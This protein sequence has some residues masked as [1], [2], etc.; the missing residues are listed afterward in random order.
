MSLRNSYWA[1]VRL[2]GYALLMLLS[3]CCLLPIHSVYR[4]SFFTTSSTFQTPSKIAAARKL[5]FREDLTKVEAKYN[6]KTGFREV[7][8]VLKKDLELEFK[9]L[10][11]KLQFYKNER[12]NIALH[13]KDTFASI[14]KLAEDI[15]IK[16]K[17]VFK[18]PNYENVM[19]IMG[20][21]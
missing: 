9:E 3:R 12:I 20:K 21:K 13:R 19:Y 18:N 11:Y 6:E 4:E 1:R 7:N 15:R 10:K 14:S 5:G 2:L 8:L 16:L 17:L